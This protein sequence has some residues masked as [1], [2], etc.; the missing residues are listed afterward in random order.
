MYVVYLPRDGWNGPE[1]PRLRLTLDE[2]SYGETM[3]SHKG[4]W[5]NQR[6]AEERITAAMPSGA[7]NLRR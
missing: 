1:L 4:I 2:R 5:T 6:E 7:V 3:S